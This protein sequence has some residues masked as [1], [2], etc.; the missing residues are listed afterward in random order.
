MWD[1]ILLTSCSFCTDG[2][3][4][5]G[6][7]ERGGGSCVSGERGSWDSLAGFLLRSIVSHRVVGFCETQIRV[8][9]AGLPFELSIRRP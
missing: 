2:V 3:I 4:G 8:L 6:L 9:L 7:R 5:E 1:A